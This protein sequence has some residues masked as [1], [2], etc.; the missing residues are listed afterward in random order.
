MTAHRWKRVADGLADGIAG[1]L[2]LI[3]FWFTGR[4]NDLG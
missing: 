4:W 1:L 2:R 3:W